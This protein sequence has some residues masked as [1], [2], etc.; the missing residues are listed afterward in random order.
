MYSPLF[1]LKVGSRAQPMVRTRPGSWP[2]ISY[3]LTAC[4]LAAILVG[5]GST[6]QSAS[7]SARPVVTIGYMDNGA[8]PEVIAVAQKL[9]SKR[10]KADV[11]V[12]YFDSGP[13][14]LGAVAS[15]AL[16]FM[17]GIGNPPV[18]SAIARGV[19]LEVIWSQELFTTGEGLAVRSEAGIQSIKDL[20]GKNVGLV[21]G[22]TSEFAL[23]ALL[24]RAGVDPGS[25]HKLNMSP[26]AIRTAWSNHSIDAAY[27]WNPVFDAISHDHGKIL[28]T[29]QDIR[30]EAPIYSLSI[31]NS[32]WAKEHPELVKQFIL[33]QNDAVTYYK[34]HPQDA[35]QVIAKRAGI[36]VELAR[37][38]ME[39]YK[40]FGL[41]EQFDAEA[42][43]KGSTVSNSL[44]AT[45][46]K[47]AATF[48]QQKGSLPTIPDKLEQHVN[49]TYVESV[50]TT[51]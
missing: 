3:L 48:L 7:S 34:E 24:T 23:N 9:F 27:V 6:N 47:A 37:T 14:S 31:V 51:K 15:G 11:Q 12:K 1:Q 10:M 36:P 18:V 25:V 29:D 5:C 17:T 33:A 28:A 45:S 38:E 16:Q 19:P 2:G 44:V 40:I 13:A 42:L 46:L 50:I 4:I 22:S 21:L 49:P 39:G 43:G 35:L 8:E 30:Q 41:T 32:D 26:A 20:K